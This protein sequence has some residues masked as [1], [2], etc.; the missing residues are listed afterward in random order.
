MKIQAQV[1]TRRLLEGELIDTIH[2]HEDDWGMRNLYPLSAL[3]EAMRDI[4]RAAEAGEKNRAPDGVGWMDVH[5]IGKSSVDYSSVPLPLAAITS[6][7]EPLMPRVRRFTATAV[8]GFTAGAHDPYGTYQTDAYCFGFNAD[9][10]V[11]IE[12]AGD[13]VK[14][15]WFECRTDDPQRIETLRKCFLRID[16]LAP[17]IIVDYWLDAAGRIADAEFLDAYVAALK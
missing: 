4:T 16:A 15:I 2:I 17:S 11:K 5:V 3:T 14:S 13:T 10:F 12:P 8:A 1:I 6:A 7:V 9:C